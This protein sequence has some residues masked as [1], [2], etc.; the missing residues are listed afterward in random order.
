MR[1]PWEDP[2]TPESP[3]WRAR[4]STAAR[5]GGTASTITW[6][7]SRVSSAAMVSETGAEPVYALPSGGCFGGVT[8]GVITGVGL[9][10]PEDP[11]G[12][13]VACGATISDAATPPARTIALI[14]FIVL[15]ISSPR[16]RC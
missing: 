11:D 15:R 7:T 9:E 16:E 2:I 13:V 14:F 8:V 5:S 1:L 3:A 12:A 6:P 4:S 10:D